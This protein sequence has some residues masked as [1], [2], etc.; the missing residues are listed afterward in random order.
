MK[1]TLD[2]D[3]TRVN[4]TIVEYLREMWFPDQDPFTGRPKPVEEEP[5]EETEE[6]DNDTITEAP[7][8]EPVYKDIGPVTLSDVYPEEEPDDQD[9]LIAYLRG[10]H[11]AMLALHVAEWHGDMPRPGAPLTM[12]HDYEPTKI[13]PG[14]TIGRI[15]QAPQGL[16]FSVAANVWIRAKVNPAMVLAQQ[17][18]A[19]E[20]KKTFEEM[21]P[22][23]Y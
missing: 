10:E 3:P 5:D 23:P 1:G 16:R 7:A 15:R 14:P 6:S 20:E 18:Q 8:I 21:L 2:I 9:L 11:E 19:Q 4:R 12:E 13:G 17:Q 22:E